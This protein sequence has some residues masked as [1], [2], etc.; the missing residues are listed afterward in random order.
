MSLSALGSAMK[1]LL[2]TGRFYRLQ[3]SRR[4]IGQRLAGRFAQRSGR[5]VM[6]ICAWLS[7]GTKEYTPRVPATLMLRRFEVYFGRSLSLESSCLNRVSSCTTVVGKRKGSPAEAVGRFC[8]RN[9]QV[10][11]LSDHESHIYICRW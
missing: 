2:G 6:W 9:V 11:P 1:V 10:R 7:S 8:S 3:V 4:K 5:A